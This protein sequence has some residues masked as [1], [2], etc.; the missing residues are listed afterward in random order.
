VGVVSIGHGDRFDDASAVIY[1]FSP[2]SLQ[3]FSQVLLQ[4][5]NGLCECSV[6]FIAVTLGG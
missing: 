5:T 1:C 6:G 2:L 4:K 3:L